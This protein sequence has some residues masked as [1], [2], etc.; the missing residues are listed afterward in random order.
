MDAASVRFLRNSLI[1]SLAFSDTENMAISF[2]PDRFPVR[3]NFAYISDDFRFVKR[4]FSPVFPA[5][6]GSE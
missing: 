6:A 3:Q 2:F 4:Y 5:G 1:I